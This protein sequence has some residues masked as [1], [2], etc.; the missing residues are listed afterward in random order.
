MQQPK[1]AGAR[2]PHVAVV[3]AAG[4]TRGPNFLFTHV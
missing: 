3:A 4:P 2:N 1:T